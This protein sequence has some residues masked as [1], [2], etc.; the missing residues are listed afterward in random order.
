MARP[1]E[2]CPMTRAR[3]AENDER[4]DAHR[5]VRRLATAAG[6]S[7]SAPRRLHDVRCLWSL[8]PLHDLELD[9]IALGERLEAAALDGAEVDEDVWPPFARDDA[10]AFS[11]VEPLHG[12][13]E[14]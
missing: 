9:A 3:R 2:R 1:Q 6:F 7:A 11:V 4:P 13:L 14:T 8:L 5:G 12:A 10:V